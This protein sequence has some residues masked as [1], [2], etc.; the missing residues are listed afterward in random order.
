MQETQV[1]SLG[2]KDPLEKGMATHSSI[3]A[4]E[5]PWM[6]EPGGLQSMGSQKSQTRLSDQVHSTTHMGVSYTFPSTKTTK[7]MT[8]WYKMNSNM[9]IKEEP[10]CARDFLDNFK[11]MQPN[12][13]DSGKC[14]PL[15]QQLSIINSL[16]LSSRPWSS[17]CCGV[18][19]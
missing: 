19:Q 11:E 14:S 2:W 12:I 8:D 9:A 10:V 16:C 6:E 18:L 3:P 15:S 1:R 5:S 17:R 7:S 4:W 13:E